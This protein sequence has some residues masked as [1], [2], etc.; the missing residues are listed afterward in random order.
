[1]SEF[2]VDGVS[3]RVIRLRPSRVYQLVSTK[4]RAAVAPRA[5]RAADAGRAT[6][7]R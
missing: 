4:S 7:T 3:W 5:A 1:M 2:V 6:R